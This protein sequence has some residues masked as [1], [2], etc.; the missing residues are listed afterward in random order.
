[1]SL[2]A[3]DFQRSPARVP[4]GTNAPTAPT[5]DRFFAAST[6]VHPGYG[7]N[8]SRPRP[9]NYRVGMKQYASWAFAAANMNADAVAGVPL[10]LYVHV[11]PNAKPKR[12]FR[13]GS[14]NLD[15]KA[16]IKALNRGEALLYDTRPIRESTKRYLRGDSTSSGIRPASGIWQ[17]AV[18]FGGDIEEVMEPHPALTSLKLVNNWYNGHEYTCLRILDLQITGNSYLL[19]ANNDAIWRMPPQ[20]TAVIPDPSNTNLIAG[21]SYGYGGNEKVFLAEDVIQFRRPNPSDIYYGMGWFEANWTALGLHNSKREEDTARHD[22][23]S[24]PDWLLAIKNGGSKEVLTRLETAVK[25]KLQGTDKAGNFLAISGDVS[26]TALNL[27]TPEVGTPTRVIEE[28]AAV[29]KV[30]VAMLLTNDPNKAGAEPARLGWYR[31]SVHSY[32]TQD[33]ETLNQSHLPRWAG[34]DEMLLAYDPA[35][36]EDREALTKEVVALK[37]AGITS[38]N[39]G[40]AEMG[41]AAA[42]GGDVIHP[43]AGVSGGAAAVAG[44]LAVNQNDRR[45]NEDELKSIKT[46][47]P[48]VITTEVEGGEEVPSQLEFQRAAFLGF[49]KDKT[50]GGIITNLTDLKELVSEVGLPA[51]KLH[52]QP[53]IPV[54]AQ[55]GPIV[56]G[57]P[58][59]DPAGNIIG[60]HVD[61]LPSEVIT[62]DQTGKKPPKGDGA[63]TNSEDM[64]KV[65][66]EDTE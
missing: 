11:R 61:I 39:E 2:L 60:G 7:Q 41:Y 34:T 55:D 18:E 59:K 45:R 40:R 36:F 8:G 49:Q 47:V 26:A 52:A 42:T 32:C 46:A 31:T 48:T 57:K 29:S 65:S 21:Y 56:N 16:W 50:A 5:Q 15:Q 20:W 64:P 44:N 14:G 22:N 62:I 19:Y 10:R 51:S 27:P 43:P 33:E 30:P 13:D 4:W 54:I 53:P 38:V 24:R 1:M 6:L 63:A 37:A 23:M 3:S 17:K 9:W 12:A 35:A 66:T 25:E 58:M 28:I